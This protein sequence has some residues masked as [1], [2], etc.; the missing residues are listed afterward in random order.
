MSFIPPP[1]SGVRPP[2]RACDCRLGQGRRSSI[3]LHYCLG[4]QLTLSGISLVMYYPPNTATLPTYLRTTLPGCHQQSIN[5]DDRQTPSRDVI[6]DDLPRSRTEPS[7]PPST[8][9]WRRFS[10][11]SLDQALRVL[12]VPP[13]T[14]RPR[15]THASALSFPRPLTII[16]NALSRQPREA[17][18]HAAPRRRRARVSAAQASEPARPHSST[19]DESDIRPVR[20]RLS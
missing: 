3:R 2:M 9:C 19:C 7:L 11:V 16:P 13:H 12:V 20:G 6:A 18:A 4:V 14:P 8:T 1:G 15:A 10:L 5:Q 17:E